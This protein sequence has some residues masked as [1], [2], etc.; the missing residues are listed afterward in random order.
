MKLD[1]QIEWDLDNPHAS[2]EEFAEI[3]ARD[4]GLAGEF[5]TAVAHLIHEQVQAHRK[6]LFLSGPMG[7]AG[8][9]DDVRASFLP[10]L[11]TGAR[12]LDQVPS[13]TPLLNYISDSEIERTE[14]ERDKEAQRRRKRTARNRR[15]ATLP[16]REP[17]R[18]YRTPGIGFAPVDPAN[19]QQSVLLSQ[20]TSRRAAAAAAQINIA[21]MVASENRPEDRSPMGSPVLASAPLAASSSAAQASQSNASKEP[22]SKGLFK[23]PNV[24]SSLLRSRANMK[25]QTASTAAGTRF[26]L[27]DADLDQAPPVSMVDAARAPISTGANSAKRARE[28]ER[29]AKEREFIDGQHPNEIDGEWHCS[30]C[31]CPA[32]IAV[33][34]RKGPLGDKTQCG[35]CGE[36]LCLI[37][38]L[39]VVTHLITGKYWHRHRRPRPVEYHSD[40]A[41]HQNL[42][43]EAARAKSAGR[44]RARA[45]ALAEAAAAAKDDDDDDEGDDEAAPP[46]LQAKEASVAPDPPARSATRSPI[47]R[48]KCEDDEDSSAD[49]APLAEQM[50]K[51]D[52]RSSANE[53]PAP[54]A[55]GTPAPPSVATPQAPPSQ[56]R[57]SQPAGVPPTVRRQSASALAPS[58]L[59]EAIAKLRVEYPDDSLDIMRHRVVGEDALVWRIR[60]EDCPEKV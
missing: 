22:K 16:D 47:K 42:R 11:S 21:N 30:N 36:F 58:W 24:P 25:A 14:R 18:T 17:Q 35:P 57:D 26:L 2:P 33:G 53:T 55:Q 38:A 60:C 49:E 32:S 56:Q 59:T 45:A 46:A 9:E 44:R 3:Y 28:L 27:P 54:D 29:E 51:Q 50:R 31:G 37:Y 23:P 15:G 39:L 1:D 40:L 41:Y 19:L 34:R 48:T 52:S 10:P 6:S 4:L 7:T 5:K 8:G 12:A 43:D 13:F 20:P